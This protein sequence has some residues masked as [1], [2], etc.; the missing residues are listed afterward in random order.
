[1]IKMTFLKMVRSSPESSHGKF[2]YKVGRAEFNRDDERV[3]NGPL[4]DASP[5]N[6]PIF[7]ILDVRRGETSRLWFGRIQLREN[8]NE[9][10]EIADP[11]KRA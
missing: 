6:G 8:E 5:E 2:I 11:E 7:D 3:R 4:P 10:W 9:P 1:M